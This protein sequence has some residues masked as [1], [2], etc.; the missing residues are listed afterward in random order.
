MR[1]Q[2]LFSENTEGS[3]PFAVRCH[4]QVVVEDALAI[5]RPLLPVL[6]GRD[7]NVT[8]V[9]DVATTRLEEVA[10]VAVG[11]EEA[12]ATHTTAFPSYIWHN[13]CNGGRPQKPQSVCF[14]VMFLK[15]EKMWIIVLKINT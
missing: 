5:C 3:E 9:V 1:G 4:Q 13:F 12:T 6:D 14:T 7:G 15:F 2:K 8:P 10:A 11:S